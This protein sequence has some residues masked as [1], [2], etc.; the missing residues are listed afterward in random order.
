MPQPRETPKDPK[1][2]F[3]PFCRDGFEGVAECPDHELT[4]LPI[5]RLP[6]LEERSLAEVAFF[7]DPRLGR[8]GV[9]LGAWLVVVGFL[10]PFV[11]A[12]ELDASALEVAIDGAHN[13]WL[14]PGAALGVLWVLW[15]RR[16]RLGMQN[17]RLAVAGLA[18][19]GALPLIYTGRRIALVAGAQVSELEWR[20]GFAVMVAGLATAA[21]ASTRLG[22]IGETERR[23]EPR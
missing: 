9:L 16:S 17:A 6:P 2:L 21:L 11:R 5:D 22:A 19:V 13:L 18:L 23:R 8:G 10:G 20:W 3:C 4:L 14:T 7:V 15:A 12:G 1:I